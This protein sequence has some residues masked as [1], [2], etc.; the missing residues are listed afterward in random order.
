MRGTLPARQWRK[1]VAATQGIVLAVAAAGVLPRPLTVAALAV[2]LAL[3]VE[4]FGHD[5]GW[6][7]LRRAPDRALTP[8]RALMPGGRRAAVPR[9]VP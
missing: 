7:W 2:A 9:Y 6:L 3:L 4:S 5:V 8:G 1:V